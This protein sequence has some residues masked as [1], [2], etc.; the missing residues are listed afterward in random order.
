M[1]CELILGN[2]IQGGVCLISCPVLGTPHLWSRGVVKV[3]CGSSLDSRWPDE[4]VDPVELN[5][6]PSLPCLKYTHS[7]LTQKTLSLTHFKVV[8]CGCGSAARE[9]AS[10]SQLLFAATSKIIGLALEPQ[11]WQSIYT[12]IYNTSM[13]KSRY[14]SQHNKE[15]QTTRERKV[16]GVTFFERWCVYMVGQE[17]YNFTTSIVWN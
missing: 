12:Y 14:I 6:L 8:W 11:Q 9:G 10:K 15:T 7:L 17:V 4:T 16:V 2:A 3:G 5:H 1:V 13:I